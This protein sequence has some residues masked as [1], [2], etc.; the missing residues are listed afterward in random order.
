MTPSSIQSPLQEIVQ[1]EAHATTRIEDAK[2][3]AGEEV[4]V[5]RTEDAQRVAARKSTLKKNATEEIR[6]EKGKLGD[7]LQQGKKTME[8]EKENLHNAC[9]KNEGGVIAWLIDQFFSF[10]S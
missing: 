10:T 1:A 4:E 3:L 8:K 7:V 9:K 6:A 5:F 2:R